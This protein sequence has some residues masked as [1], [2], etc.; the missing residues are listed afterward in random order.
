M[1]RMP[2]SVEDAVVRI[3][4]IANTKLPSDIG[5]ALEAAAGWESN[6][7]A[8][9]QLGA[10]MDNVK[11]AENT[12]RPMCQDTGVPVFYVSGAFDGSVAGRIVEGL[13]RATAEIPLR[14]NTVDPLTRENH[15][16]NLGEGMPI[17]RYHPT[18]DDFLQITVMPKGAGSENMTKLAMLNPSEGEKG[19]RDFVV[20][21]V[22]DAGGRPCPPTVVG[23]GIGG[24][25]ETCIEMAKEAL[26]FPIDSDNPDKKLA[27][28]EEEL[29]VKLN[30]SGLGPMGLG[31]DTTV[32]AVRIRKAHCHTASL[33]VAVAVGCWATRRASVRM[34]PDGTTEYFQGAK[35]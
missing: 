30:S 21:A 11:E 23:V 29:F 3:L 10:I 6:S 13:R 12:G 4:R 32:L 14:P 2:E 8:Y 35:P 5:W 25:A 26:L 9:T 24:T 16:D 33:P 15:G 28:M 18:D 22:L 31:G 27:K 1:I 7:V 20:N 19:I 34:Y 17:I